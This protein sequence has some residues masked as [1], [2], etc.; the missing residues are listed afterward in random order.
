MAPVA[1]LLVPSPADDEGASVEGAE[2]A[3]EALVLR[4]RQDEL[5]HGQRLMGEAEEGGRHLD[6]M[7]G[8]GI[9]VERQSSGDAQRCQQYD[10]DVDHNVARS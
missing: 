2:E 5:G 3:E 6:G 10:G 8:R 7:G 9:E 1:H 4:R